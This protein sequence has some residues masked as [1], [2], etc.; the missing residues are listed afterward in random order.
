MLSGCGKQAARKLKHRSCWLLTARWVT[1]DRRQRQR[2]RLTST[3]MSSVGSS[4]VTSS[5]RWS[6]KPPWLWTKRDRK[7]EALLIATACSSRPK[8]E[9]AGHWNC[10]PVK[11]VVRRTEHA[12]AIARKPCVGG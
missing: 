6:E 12:E 7:E 9:R 11:M 8:G 4:K 3:W 1:R 2:R 10:W 5:W